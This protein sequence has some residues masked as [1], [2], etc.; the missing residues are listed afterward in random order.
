[1]EDGLAQMKT[2]LQGPVPTLKEDRALRRPGHR[3]GITCPT[4]SVRGC[5]ALRDVDARARLAH[6]GLVVY[7][8][9]HQYKGAT[10]KEST[11]PTVK[12]LCEDCCPND[13]QIYMS[14]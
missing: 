4:D 1:M 11:G 9:I 12:R 10:R 13:D 14:I 3:A 7:D 6:T 8:K 2:G 5:K